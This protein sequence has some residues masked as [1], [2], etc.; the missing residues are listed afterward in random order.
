[1]G[2]TALTSTTS[3]T[4]GM[5]SKTFTVN[6][7]NTSTAFAIGQTVRIFS[8]ADT[9][10]FMAGNITAFSGTGLTILSAAYGGFSSASDWQIVASGVVYTTPIAIGSSAG[11]TNQ[12]GNCVAIGTQCGNFNQGGSGVAIGYYAGSSA[13]G[14]AGVAI[15]SYAAGVSQG[16]YG[17]A[18]GQD[19][20]YQTQGDYA[21]AI[22][23]GAGTSNQHA[24]SIVLNASGAVLNTD[25]TSR[26]FIK[27]IRS[28]A[29][30]GLKALYYNTTTFEVTSAP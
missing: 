16:Q 11:A 21:I 27:P 4:P 5:G 12:G 1:M 22:G 24:N 3:N 19:A 20:G 18:I 2:Y 6:V 28:V 23:Y 8:T 17:V 26:C 9:T 10:I 7:S 15:G 14:L 29:I 13:Q 25:G 30:T